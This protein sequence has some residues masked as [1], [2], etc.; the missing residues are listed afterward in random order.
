MNLF[1]GLTPVLKLAKKH[2]PEVAIWFG[3][4]FDGAAVIFGI[5][6][7]PHA[8]DLLEE[9]KPDTMLQKAEVLAPAYW[10]TIAC[11]L[12]GTFL[13]LK[14]NKLHLERTAV[15]LGIAATQKDKLL[16]LTEETK[17][18]VGPKKMQEIEDN[19]EDRKI[20]MDKVIAQTQN[21]P[22]VVNGDTL[23][24]CDWN[25]YAFYST[26]NQIQEYATELLR[27]TM[28]CK[29]IDKADVET[30]I[31]IPGKKQDYG[32]GWNIDHPPVLKIARWKDGP[33]GKPM[34]VLK[35]TPEPE[36]GW[37]IESGYLF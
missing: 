31:G 11:F 15:A 25:N 24:V 12:V 18:L 22:V 33:D 9:K 17:K 14:G 5:Q 19:V 7:T 20:D 35:I 6:E 13:I 29:C 8:R 34:G 3:V 21:L 1:S 37:V 26:I 4:A 2:L 23:F 30:I 32:V 16:A 36:A 10:K 27:E 28:A